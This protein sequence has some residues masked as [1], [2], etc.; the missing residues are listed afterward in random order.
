MFDAKVV[1]AGNSTRA[2]KET[3]FRDEFGGPGRLLSAWQ[4]R[5]TSIWTDGIIDAAISTVQL[6][7]IS[8]LGGLMT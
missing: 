2:L 3:D 8:N 1:T 6:G 4:L 5:A 7:R